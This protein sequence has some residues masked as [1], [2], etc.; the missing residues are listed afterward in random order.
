MTKQSWIVIIVIFILAFALRF[1]HYA[2]RAPF[3]WDQNRDYGQV[4]KIA[5]GEY[6]P[7]GPVAKGAG[8]FYLGSL[9]Y[10]LLYP[11]YTL[12]HGSLSSL[13]L[14]SLTFD[15]LVAGFLYLLLSRGLG[16]TR[17]L[18][19]SLV[20]ASSWFIIEASHISWNVALV[21]LWSLLTLYA[22]YHAIE[23]HSRPHFY[24]LG[25][26]AGIS[27]HVHVAAIPVIHLLVIVFS[28]RL[29][30]PLLSWVKAVIL[31]VIPI[32]PL[33]V[34]DLTHSFFNL[35]LLRDFLGYHNRVDTPLLQMTWMMFIKL[36]K[37]VSGIFVSS[38]RDNLILGIITFALA[39]K[40]LFSRHLLTKIA[41]TVVIISSLLIVLFRDY[42]F[43]EYYFGPAYI[44]ICL[45]F[46]S[47]LPK[48]ILYFALAIV[49]FL[50]LRSYTLVPT[51]YSLTVKNEI[52][53]T[54]ANYPEPIDISYQFDP[55]RDGG[56]GYLVKLKNIRLD[57]N[58]KTRI[59]LTD[60]LNTPLYIDGELARDLTQIGAIKSA[61]YIVQ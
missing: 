41:G 13:P 56:L 1:Y 18:V 49:L 60:K 57:P 36:G 40:S 15:A 28:R 54:L 48:T 51:P 11:A 58:S 46:L 34:Y 59:L 53:D 23:H 61:L 50:N 38:F 21:P 39:A 12:M 27:L 16:R 2:N 42:G 22:L 3:D 45:I 26:L 30:F 8:G 5:A 19:F 37:V 32:I 7:L 4:Q 17:A 29:K 25:L 55:G 52:V 33:I 20:W 10:Y 44:A 6:V 31:G 24:L 35:H 43:P 9:Y 14:T 47:N